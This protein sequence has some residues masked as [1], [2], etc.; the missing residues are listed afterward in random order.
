MAYGRLSA[1]GTVTLNYGSSLNRTVL[2]DDNN[3]LM[4]C[5]TITGCTASNGATLFSLPSHFP[6][7]DVNLRFCAPILTSGV[8]SVGVFQIDMNGDLITR[9]AL[10]NA[11]VCLAGIAIHLNNPFYNSTIGN[12]DE[13][14][15]T[16]PINYG[17]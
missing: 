10:N 17:Y 7:P 8:Y 15:M 2:M 13:S 3:I 16:S 4:F 12:N 6:R 1:I 5:C 11:Y 9:Q 14:T